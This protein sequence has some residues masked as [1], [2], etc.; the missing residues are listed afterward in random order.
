MIRQ[1]T[2]FTAMFAGIV[3]AIAGCDKA[4]SVSF[5]NDVNPIL[6]KYCAECHTAQGEGTR[7]SGYEVGSYESVM[8]GTKY[9]PVVVA[10]DSTSSTL[11]RLVAGKVDKSIQMPHGKQQLSAEEIAVIQNWIDQGAQNN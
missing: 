11:Y 8:M 4:P 5:A 1:K 7:E 2:L 6:N 9:G 3:A 10:G